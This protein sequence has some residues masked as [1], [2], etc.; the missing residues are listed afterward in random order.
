MFGFQMNLL[1]S[2]DEIEIPDA[3]WKLELMDDQPHSG[4]DNT[5]RS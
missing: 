5:I 4:Y 3:N 1:T 2:C